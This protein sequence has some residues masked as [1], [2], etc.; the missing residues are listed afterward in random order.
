MCGVKPLP[1][2]VSPILWIESASVTYF[3]YSTVVRV[4]I[5]GITHLQ[6]LTLTNSTHLLIHATHD[7]AEASC[8]KVPHNPSVLASKL[9]S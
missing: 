2:T 6:L 1:T 5:K 4:L 8:E 3:R 7:I 9:A